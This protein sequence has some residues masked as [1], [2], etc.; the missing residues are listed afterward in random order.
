MQDCRTALHTA[1]WRG[2]TEVV[3]HLVEAGA[4]ANIH[5]GVSIKNSSFSFNKVLHGCY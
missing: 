4:D 1:T 2:N 3:R 5:D